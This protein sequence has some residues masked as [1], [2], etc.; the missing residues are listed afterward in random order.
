MYPRFTSY[1]QKFSIHFF[2]LGMIAFTLIPFLYMLSTSVKSP[3]EVYGQFFPS[4]ISWSGFQQVF[5]D[6]PILTWA[7]NSAFI[8]VTQ[9][10]LQ[11]V[12]AFF[13]AYTFVR[14][15][16]P[17]RTAIFYFVIATMIIPQ[18][19]LMIPTFVT[20]NM[21]NWVNSFF[22]VIVPHMASGYAIF[23]LRQ[24]MVGIPKEL[25]EAA[26]V[27][28]CGPL[29]ILWHIYL[30]ATIPALSALSIILFVSHWND[31]YWPLLVLVDE[32]KLTLPVA[33]VKFQN[34]GIIDM[35][36]TMAVATLSTLPILVLYFL[37]QK[38]FIE[39]FTHSGIK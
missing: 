37:A 18:Q 35:V 2:L 4:S 22:G 16:F 7:L 34:E 14:F 36:P 23:L 10:F 11:V 28:G 13:A 31:F 1:L 19:A 3:D 21:M 26:A 38:K 29:R 5:A 25:A 39:G 32:N 12:I 24:F 8:A 27:D 17:G 9:T 33:L 15:D 20:I 30:P 6:T